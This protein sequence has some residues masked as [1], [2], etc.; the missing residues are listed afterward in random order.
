MA[1][2]NDS[3]FVTARTEG[4][5]LPPELL[6][7]IVQGDTDLG[8]LRPEEYGLAKGERLNEAVARAWARCKTYWQAFRSA[9][10]S[11]GATETGVTETRELWLQPLFRELGYERL[12]YQS[13]PEQLGEQSFHLSHRAGEAP[14]APRVHTLGFMQEIER[15]H[16]ITEPGTGPRRASAHSLVQGYLNRADDHLWAIVTNGRRLRL[17]RDNASLSRTAYVEFDLEAM[18]EEGVYADFALLYLLLHRSR[19]PRDRSDAHTCWME[20]WREA[21]HREGARALDELR[22]GVEAAIRVLGRGLLAHPQNGALVRRLRE[23]ELTLD[24]YYRQ[25]LQLVY[26][27]LFLLV[28]EERDLL[29]PEDTRVPARVIYDRHYGVCRLRALAEQRRGADRHDDLWRSLRVTFAALDGGSVELELP[30]LNGGL[31]DAGACADVDASLIRNADLLAAVRA[32]SFVKS[33]NSVRRVNYRDLDLEELGSVYESLLDYRPTLDANSAPPT[34]DLIAGS[35]RK[36][37][38]TYYTPTELVQELIRNTLEP[39][40]DRALASATTPEGK[41]TALQTLS[42][43]DP[44]CGS[45]GFLL[46]AARRIGR[47]IARVRSGGIEPNPAQIREGVR[48]AIRHCIYG[49]DVNPLVVDICRLVLWLESHT[50]GRPLPFLDH[51]VQCGNS[52]VGVPLPRQVEAKRRELKARRQELERE[53]ARRDMS[54]RERKAALAETV[55]AGWPVSWPDEAFAP[56]TGDEKTTAAGEKKRNKQERMGQL[57]LPVAAERLAMADGD[58]ARDAR[59]IAGQ[60]EEC[61]ADVHAKQKR[62]RRFRDGLLARKRLAADAWTA[63]FFWPLRADAPPPPTREQL[64]A[65]LQNEDRLTAEQQRL[66]RDLADENRFLHWHLQFPEVFERGG[67]DCVIGNPPWEMLQL[68]EQQFFAARDPEIAR[69]SGETRKRAIRRLE[70]DRPE[71]GKA[72]MEAKHDA[73]AQ[74]KFLRES[75]RFPLTTTGKLNTYALF[76][77]QFRS[78]LNAQG[79]AGLICPTGIATDDSTKA[80]FGDLVACRALAGLTD[81]ENREALF[82]DVDSRFKFCTLTMAG[83]PV[84]RASFAFFLTNTSQRQDEQRRFELSPYDIAL[85]NPNTRTCPVFRTRADAELTK[86]IYRRV[87]VLVNEAIGENPWGVTFRQG[88][89][90]MT[91]DSGLFRTEPGPGYVPLYEGK[92][93]QAFDHRAAGIV[94][95]TANVSRQAQPDSTTPE[96]YADP[97]FIPTARYWVDSEEVE[98]RLR[99]WR[100]EWLLAFKD[101]TA[102]TNERTAIFGLLPRVGVGHTAPLMFPAYRDA[103]LAAVLLANLNSLCFDYTARQ[104]MGGI[105]LT[106]SY[107]RQLPVLPPD[108]YTPEEVAFVAARVLELVYTAWD[109][110]PFAQDVGYEGPPFVWDEERRA[111]LR[112]QLDAFYFHKYGLTEEETRYVLDPKAVHGDDFPGE[113]FRVLKENEIKKHGEYRTQRLVLEYYRAWPDWLGGRREAF[114]RWLSPRAEHTATPAGN[115]YASIQG[116][117]SPSATSEPAVSRTVDDGAM[118]RR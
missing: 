29:F 114:E 5:L 116:T 11:L 34:F 104:K 19:L 70:Q 64:T 103:R 46:A 35:E 27:L 93:F 65:L 22:V 24:G 47:E 61:A 97:D 79:R 82:R 18:M 17:L 32:L 28:I 95:N 111:H 16:S 90:N 89:F 117:A 107:L 118:R 48:D 68:E 102:V 26:R 74:C 41:L 20:R 10:E 43:C 6:W 85:L 14:D 21:A 73:D 99:Q 101:V 76:A 45:G 25:L 53:E 33:G 12:V 8:G 62:Y 69:L 91:S 100:Q 94:V 84:K 88:L 59:E 106:Y 108:T 37:T 113:T 86:A 77:E 78:L 13:Q 75:T 1:K 2:S 42:V 72:F 4:G 58:D 39:V 66:I 110:Q 15:L 80:F 81:F 105:H 31:F 83:S 30:A 67:F 57:S 63:A 55:Y 51:R 9:T 115:G 92:M 38:G 50:Q 112:A 71:L 23:G 36:T 49:V 96:Q 7:R 87:P 54:P 60:A 3:R 44:A 109:L 56:V 52:L 40:I 98:K